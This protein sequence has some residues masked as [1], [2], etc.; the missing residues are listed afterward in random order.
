[1][2]T[3]SLYCEGQEA[4]V[5]EVKG[6]RIAEPISISGSWLS[7]NY[8]NSIREFKSPR[9]A[10]DSS[11]FIV[12]PAMTLQPT[13]LIYNFHEGSAVLIFRKANDHY[14]IWESE[15]DSLFR[16]LGDVKII[17]PEKINFL[18][19]T[20]V[21]ISSS[22]NTNNSLILEALLFK[23][24]YLQSDGETIEFKDDRQIIGLDNFHFYKPVIDYY[25]AGLQVDQVDL[26]K[27]EN[28]LQ[29]FGFKFNG[30][31]L[32]LY[33]LKCLT[34]EGHRCMEV[35]FGQLAYKLWRN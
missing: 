33:K 2:L 6:S 5:L 34:F 11:L 23:G 21:K 17:S 1:M 20:F 10:Q 18:N 24:Y 14:E 30:D 26:G 22:V 7:E 3:S 35:D 29:R 9:K 13:N 12:I 8:Y 25:D 28:D 31:T 19:T 15:H 4:K 16:W 27:S 32:E